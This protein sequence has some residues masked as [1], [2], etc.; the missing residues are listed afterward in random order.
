MDLDGLA[1]LIDQEIRGS[2]WCFP[3]CILTSYANAGGLC[4]VELP[5]D[6]PR[7]GKRVAATAINNCVGGTATVFKLDDG[8]FVAYSTLSQGQIYQARNTRHWKARPITEEE[9]AIAVLYAKGKAAHFSGNLMRDTA[10]ERFFSVPFTPVEADELLDAGDYPNLA[11][12]FP[13][14]RRRTLDA[15]AV[16]QGA[17]LRIW[18]GTNFTGTLLIDITGPAVIS[19]NSLYSDYHPTAAPRTTW[20]EPLNTQFPTRRYRSD[21]HSWIKGSARLEGAGI[22]RS[23]KLGGA[24]KT[25]VELPIE[26]RGLQYETYLSATPKRYYVTVKHDRRASSWGQI[27]I[28]EIT[29]KGAV[30]RQEYAAPT[31]IPDN[32][33]WRKSLTHSYSLTPEPASDPCVQQV[34]S[35]NY[36]NRLDGVLYRVDPEQ[37][38]ETGVLR[39]VVQTKDVRATLTYAKAKVVSGACQVG[40]AKREKVK[41]KK[42]DNN[43]EVRAIVAFQK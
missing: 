39:N 6:I 13:Q 28:Y 9:Y 35:D 31:P 27:S 33:D 7:I 18:S 20:N 5:F 17:R 41:V 14:L 1:G 21:M 38:I 42:I 19:N 22:I 12:R 16:A 43:V 10:Q 40:E 26:L 30:T 4:E 11:T 2:V 25:P 36:A 34:R 23:F 29:K 37:A 15:I 32:D 8:S 3:S 24:F